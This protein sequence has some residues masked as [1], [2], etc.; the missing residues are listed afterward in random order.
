[1]PEPVEAWE[2]D[3]AELP[4]DS[5]SCV[6]HKLSLPELLLGG[7]AEVCRSWRRA[8]REE[9]EL[10]RR[11]DVRHLPDVPPFTRR[12]TLENVMRSA[13]RLS[14]GQCHTFL[15]MNLDDNLFML[16]A[17]RAPFLKSLEL[18]G[19]YLSYKRG[20]ANAIKK[21]PLLEE[22]SLV[23]YYCDAEELGLIA[24]ACP[25]LKHFGLIHE[26]SCYSHHDKDP[27]DDRN[28][29]A[30]ARMH[31]LRSL[32]LVDD[33]LGNNGLAAIIDS[34]PHLEHLYIRYCCNIIMDAS[35]TAK[36]AR[37]IMDYYY[38]YFPSSEPC[39]CCFS[40][41][42]WFS[43]DDGYESY[44]P[45]DY[46]DLSLYSYLGDEIDGA[47]FEEHERIMDVKRMRRYLS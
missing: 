21:L 31:G 2:R 39:G 45:D 29:F 1:M 22:L 15:A 18:T 3:W 38:E 25:R 7:V 27:T 41:M 20:F 40:P 34:C 4:A 19:R 14:A 9:P 47:D 37:I 12:A 5:I 23:N 36:C 8:A 30:I 46:H 13:L 24:K 42:S 35:L 17:Q 6:L 26:I 16:I 33:N 43:H 44:D 32:Q 28:A 10:W 11:I